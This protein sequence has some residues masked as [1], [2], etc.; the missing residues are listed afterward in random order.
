MPLTLNNGA[1]TVTY[2]DA[3]DGFTAIAGS[4]Y[5]TRAPVKGPRYGFERHKGPAV[6][7]NL[8]TTHGFSGRELGPFIVWYIGTTEQACWDAYKADVLL[9]LNKNHTVGVPNKESFVNCTVDV[10]DPVRGSAQKSGT[11][12]YRLPC[13]IIL[14]QDRNS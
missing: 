5:W 8:T 9:I 10:F 2:L 7:G 13:L 6:D 4:K 14:G 11:S 12:L 3:V 1:A